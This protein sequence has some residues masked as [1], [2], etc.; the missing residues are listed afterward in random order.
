ML[1]VDEQKGHFEEQPKERNPLSN[2]Q[3]KESH[4]SNDVMLIMKRLEQIRKRMG[5]TDRNQKEYRCEECRDSHI[6]I[7]QETGLGRECHCVERERAKRQI[8]H[9][10]ANSGVAREVLEG[11]TFNTLQT[12]GDYDYARNAIKMSKL[13]INK[14]FIEPAIEPAPIVP[15]WFWFF[16][17]A[18]VWSGKT[19][20]A[21]AFTNE[22]INQQQDVYLFNHVA[23]MEKFFQSFKNEQMVGEVHAQRERLK[24]AKVLVWDDFLKGN[25]PD[26][27]VRY[28]TDV[29]DHRFQRKMLTIFLSTK[30]LEEIYRTDPS[31]Y[32]RI[33]EASNSKDNTL[34]MLRPEPTR[35]VCNE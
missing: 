12:S 13:F 7:N 5:F 11:K 30:S 17:Q 32:H 26:Y 25:T 15:K 31:L 8:E 27:I 34:K 35:G 1:P 19:Y 2:Y 33:V 24:N 29:L 9:L 3:P 18:N 23:G 20:L 4:V 6:I 10:V 28:I 22:L 14:H 21:Y 16:L